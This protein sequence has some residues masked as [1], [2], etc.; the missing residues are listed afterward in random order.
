[1]QQTQDFQQETGGHGAQ[2]NAA[3]RQG[4]VSRSFQGKPTVLR[5]AER[6]D[7]GGLWEPRGLQLDSSGVIFSSSRESL[8]RC[9]GTADCSKQDCDGRM[10]WG[11]TG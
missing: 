10:A 1:M 3:P 7:R 2:N 4:R 5:P 11:V 6:P 9:W 8:G